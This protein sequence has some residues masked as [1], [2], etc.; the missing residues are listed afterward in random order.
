[1]VIATKLLMR[2]RHKY[3]LFVAIV[4][5]IY[6]YSKFNIPLDRNFDRAMYHD[7][8][9]DAFLK[10]WLLNDWMAAGINSWTNP[11]SQLPRLFFEV[12]FGSKYGDDIFG[13]TLLT[14]LFVIISLLHLCGNFWR[15]EPF[16][17]RRSRDFFS[18]CI[19]YDS[20]S[21]G[22]LLLASL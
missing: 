4:L 16:L 15:F 20:N 8:V 2:I 10:G 13:I 1:M 14:A 21:V 22:N 3:V 7:Y 9:S 18:K 17:S 12:F 19:F 5:A 11:I 6:Q